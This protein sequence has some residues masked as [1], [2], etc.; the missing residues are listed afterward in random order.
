MLRTTAAIFTSIALVHAAPA[1]AQ[2]EEQAGGEKLQQLDQQVPGWL[3]DFDV[4]SVGIAYIEDGEIVFVRH[5]GLQT[6][7]YP[8]D[9]MTL[10]NVASLTKPVT[11]EVV[12]RLIDAGVLTLDT[13]LAEKYIDADVE[14]DPRSREITPRIVLNHRTGFP[15]WRFETEGTLQ[16]LHDPDAQTGYSGEGYEWMMKS[17]ALFAGDDFEALAANWV[18]EPVGMER[19]SY[20]LTQDFVGHLAVPYK[21]GEA[22][23]N[24]VRREPS[25][26]DD[27][28]TTPREYARFMID[29]FEGDAVSAELREEQRTI[30]DYTSDKPA[31]RG[32]DR[33]NF[34]PQNQGWGLGWFIY[35]Y[36]DRAIYE[37]SG[38]DHGERSLAFYDPKVKRGAVILTNGANGDEIM[39]RVAGLL[40][41]DARFAEFMLA[42]FT[43]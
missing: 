7:G 18:F 10:Y 28:R 38:G 41:G 32:E 8:A 6:W 37:H 14:N 12:L 34:C 25:A 19:T 5:Y 29:V 26:S 9:E 13:S 22:V 40:D 2:S 4:P 17:V 31:C 24:V 23:Y 16:F 21:S 11:A 43:E 36:G 27:L 35:D 1:F 39:Y 30:R 42:P 15:N 20:T 3:A 33:A